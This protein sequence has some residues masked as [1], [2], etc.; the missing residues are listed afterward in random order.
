MF[1]ILKINDSLLCIWQ[2]EM[3]PLSLM[4]FLLCSVLI[5][6]CCC[7][8][9]RSTSNTWH[10]QSV[11]SFNSKTYEHW[12]IKLNSILRRLVFIPVF[13]IRKLRGIKFPAGEKKKKKEKNK[14]KTKP[15]ASHRWIPKFRR[16]LFPLLC[17]QDWGQH[18]TYYVRFLPHETNLVNKETLGILALIWVWTLILKL[19][20]LQVLVCFFK[21]TWLW[22]FSTCSCS[23]SAGQSF[24]ICNI[25]I[26]LRFSQAL[27]QIS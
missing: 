24:F 17:H 1:F 21:L 10:L 4:T 2:L 8:F 23:C 14:P 20:W 26:H 6:I 7:S 15:A 13:Q 19:L 11:P 18:G 3:G 9:V 16:V 12:L 22:N 5:F 25:W 27:P